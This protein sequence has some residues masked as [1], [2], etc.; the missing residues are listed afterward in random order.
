MNRAQFL[1]ILTL[2]VL[3][4]AAPSISLAANSQKR[5]NQDQAAKKN[6]SVQK[7]GSG[8]KDS[9]RDRIH[10]TTDRL[11]LDDNKKLAILTGK[12]MARWADVVLTSDHGKVFYRD[13]KI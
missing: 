5:S 8:N 13:I 1:L 11:E 9:D 12:V 4:I 7:P 2:T 6:S 10:V 3:F